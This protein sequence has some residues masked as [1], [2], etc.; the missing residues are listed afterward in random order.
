MWEK[1]VTLQDVTCG[2]LAL[3]TLLETC[4]KDIVFEVNVRQLKVTHNDNKQNVKLEI[5]IKNLSI[6][7]YIYDNQILFWLN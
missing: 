1:N 3:G 2:H 7:I 6:Y 5:K 4:F